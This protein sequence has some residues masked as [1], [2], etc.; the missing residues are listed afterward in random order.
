MF[1]LT[2]RLVRAACLGAV[3]IAAPLVAADAAQ[4]M[5]DVDY[6]VLSAQP[7]AV[8]DKIEVIEFFYYGCESCNRLEAPLQ[9]WAKTLPVDVSFRRLP[10]LRRTAWVPLARVYFALEQL[11]ELERL[12]EAVY[13]A[14]HD[15]RLN[16]ANSSELHPWA[17]K[18]GIDPDKLEQLMESDVVARKVQAA[19]DATVAYGI[20][21]TPS[22]VVDGKYL[23]SGSMIG[24]L[25]ALLPIVH[26][27]IGKAREN[28]TAQ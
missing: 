5:E 28:R 14:V 15:E 22:F 8:A 12:H 17:R 6:V 27:L 11:G 3:M 19:R 10:A 25:D 16:L 23:T 13:R 2:A 20:R 7:R 24:S 26:A 18:A 21:V 4:P 1:G 9:A